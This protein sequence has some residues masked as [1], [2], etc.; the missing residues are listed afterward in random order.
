[1]N[2]S[3]FSMLATDRFYLVLELYIV[4]CQSVVQ[5]GGLEPD[6]VGPTKV[7]AH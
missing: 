4:R 2:D 3:I 1:M 6:V 7:K 5:K